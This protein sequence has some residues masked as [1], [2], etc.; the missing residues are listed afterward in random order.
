MD[1]LI[2][3]S[4]LMWVFTALVSLFHIACAVATY[5]GVSKRALSYVF[6][7]SD[8]IA[9]IVLFAAAL[10]IGAEAEEIFLAVIISAA[11]GMLSVFISEKKAAARTS[12][13]EEGEEEDNGI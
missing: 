12:A 2:F 11:V 6:I 1:T 7:A 4:P 5:L 13:A 3:S 9:H 8:A 10:V